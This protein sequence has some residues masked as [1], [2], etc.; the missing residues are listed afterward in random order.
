MGA[1]LGR[2]SERQRWL[3]AEVA[4]VDAK[5]ATIMQKAELAKGNDRAMYLKVYANLLT[6]LQTLNEMLIGRA[7]W[8]WLPITYACRLAAW[9]VYYSVSCSRPPPP[10]M[11]C[12]TPLLVWLLPDLIRA[13]CGRHGRHSW[14]Q[15][16]QCGS[17][18]STGRRDS[19][20]AACY[21][22]YA[23]GSLRAP[24]VPELGCYLPVR[25]LPTSW[26]ATN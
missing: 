14:R 6:Q 4:A 22:G 16:W 18:L 20:P 25:L 11:L 23:S 8:V 3:N 24:C 9:P 15:S 21:V 19:P 13:C 7:A 1:A 26:A 2:E 10:P 5:M 17:R 12:H